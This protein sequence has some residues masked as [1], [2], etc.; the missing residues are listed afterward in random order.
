MF[1]FLRRRD[2]PKED[3]SI[4]LADG[5]VQVRFNHRLKVAF[6]MTYDP[7]TKDATYSAL[8]AHFAKQGYFLQIVIASVGMSPRKTD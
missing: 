6:L 7:D 8:E 2:P 1:D 3:V 4:D 5:A